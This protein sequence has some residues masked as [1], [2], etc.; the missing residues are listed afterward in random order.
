MSKAKLKGF[1]APGTLLVEPSIVE[2]VT[3]RNYEEKARAFMEQ[4]VREDGK[5]GFI[6]ATETQTL[7]HG[8]VVVQTLHEWGAWRSYFLR[9][10][11][12]LKVANMDKRG[13]YMVPTQWPHLFAVGESAEVDFAHANYFNIEYQNR[14]SK[15][16][17]YGTL[18]QRQAAVAAAKARFP[19]QA[20]PQKTPEEHLRSEAKA[21][22]YRDP[23]VLAASRKY[24]GIDTPPNASDAIT[25]IE[26]EK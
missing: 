20:R 16:R 21:A 15:E 26:E 1:E 6:I 11:M 9:L 8:D 25:A 22:S 13:Y 14:L 19:G 3:S 4:N 17:N 10:G 24:L 18:A 7:R 12:K 23:E 2:G 5:W